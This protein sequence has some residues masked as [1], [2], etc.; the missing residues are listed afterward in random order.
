MNTQ[1]KQVVALALITLAATA[2]RGAITIS[3]V[4]AGDLD[5]GTTYNLTDLGQTDWALFES[6]STPLSPTQRKNGGSGIG[7]L[8][9]S[10]G[11]P[12]SAT[13][14][15]S[16]RFT[17]TDGDP[18]GLVSATNYDP[19]HLISDSSQTSTMF[20]LDVDAGPTVQAVYLFVGIGRSAAQLTATLSDDPGN[21]VSAPIYNVV[22]SF[23]HI[24]YLITY[25]ADTAGQTLTLDWALTTA[26]SSPALLRLQGAALSPIPEPASAVMLSLSCLGAASRRR[27]R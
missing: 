23:G 3:V 8:T 12:G 7:A 21:P 4:D 5:P 10:A 20:S 2:A 6:A 9:L 13:T 1:L 22:N 24:T 17:W 14:N 18:S 26:N 27:P 19:D 16:P 15:Y 11:T 25:H